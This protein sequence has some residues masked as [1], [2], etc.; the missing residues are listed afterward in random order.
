MTT[1]RLG[2]KPVGK[3]PILGA[4]FT[5]MSVFF[6][7]RVFGVHK[8]KGVILKMNSAKRICSFAAMVALFLACVVIVAPLPTGAAERAGATREVWTA[9][10][11]E[12]AQEVEDGIP[13]S[14]IITSHVKLGE[15]IQE[16]VA[17][18]IKVGVDPALV[19]STAIKQGYPAQTV[20]K[21]AL[22]AGAPFDAVLK[23]AANAGP[24]K[25]S[26]VREILTA[27]VQ[28][29]VDPSQVVHTAISDGYS[30]QIV[31]TTTL[32]AG[33]PLDV[34]VKSAIDSG[35][36]DF[37]TIYVAAAAAGKPPAAVEQAILAA[38]TPVKT[39]AA[40]FTLPEVAL[41][42]RSLEPPP[43]IFG[44]GIIVL[45][46]IPAWGPPLFDVGQLKI[47]PFLG[48]SET[49][50]DN[51]FFTPDNRK[52][53][54]I[55]TVTPG[56]RVKLPFQTHVTELNYYSVITRYGKTDYSFD[57]TTDH[58]GNAAVDFL[59]GDRFEMRLS[60]QLAHDHEPR[61]SSATGNIEVFDTNAASLS[62]AYRTS[63][64]TCLQ[65]DYT[66]SNWRYVTGHFRDREEDL[67][68]GT[69]FYRVMSRTSV[70]IE[71]GY[72]KIAY[73][74]ETLGFNSTVGTLQGG[75]I[76][77]IAART[78]GTIKAGLAQKDFKWTTKG[79]PSEMIGS[80]DVRHVFSKDTT[81]ILTAQRS[82]NEPDSASIDYFVSTGGYVE[83][84]QRLV[85]TLSAVVR[86]AYV[87]DEDTSRTDRTSFGGAGLKYRA[88]DWLEFTSD[89]NL[90]V[91][92]SNIPGN[93]YTEHSAII[94]VNVSL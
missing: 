14:D 74:D 85:T 35:V 12:M 60:D 4:L 86:G 65:I 70:F 71:Y 61:S 80:A 89:Y 31:I 90:H 29:G 7:H 93:D 78:K 24:K 37:L 11:A 25:A 32:K 92:N 13:L 10:E 66:R 50:S 6:Q 69:V 54:S 9:I 75:L 44:R 46:P 33:A 19:V 36:D 45:A 17:S 68:A 81:L 82:I 55:A 1:T 30:A 62:A 67:V 77:D 79:N 47:N 64:L 18:A 49:F 58:H 88:M 41:A 22:R 42:S 2:N 72:R 63:D 5:A 43:A 48:L 15:D 59:F 20:I 8:R 16:V 34:V 87:L 39:G 51:V 28:F 94:T 84:T 52:R 27:S 57:D 73:S 76:W 56:V 21:A 83:L 26:S 23:S 53:D 91:R 3:G 38:R 40:A